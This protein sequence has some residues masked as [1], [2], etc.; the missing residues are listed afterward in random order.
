[1]RTVST[2]LD[3]RN[4]ERFLDLCNYEGCSIS[5]ALREMVLGWCDATEEGIEIEKENKSNIIQG[6]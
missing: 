4:H 3:K 6:E 1:M 2:K 5:E